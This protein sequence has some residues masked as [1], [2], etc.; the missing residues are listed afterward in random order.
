MDHS[1]CHCNRKRKKLKKIFLSKTAC[2]EVMKLFSCSTQLSTEF[3]LLIKTKI[4]INVEVYYFR[5]L[6]S[7]YTPRKLCFFIPP[8]QTL[9]VVGILF[10][11]C[12]CVRYCWIFIKPCK[13]VYI[14]KTNTLDKKVRARGQFY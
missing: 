3:R 13:H 6:R 12:T 11:R 9:F 4:P 8:P 10:S 7:C 1:G 14:C 5:S 2:P